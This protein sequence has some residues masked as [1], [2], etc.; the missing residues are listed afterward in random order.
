LYNTNYRDETEVGLKLLQHLNLEH[1][2]WHR[3]GDLHAV[4]V[5][6]II[7]LQLREPRRWQ[8]PTTERAL[9][10]LADPSEDAALV[11]GMAAWHGS[12][13]RILLL[14]QRGIHDELPQADGAVIGARAWRHLRQLPAEGGNV[15]ISDEEVL[16]AVG[17]EPLDVLVGDWVEEVRPVDVPVV[18]WIEID[19][20]IIHANVYASNGS[21]R[22]GSGAR[23]ET[24]RPL[25]P[26]NLHLHRSARGA[27]GG[28][29]GGWNRG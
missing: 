13:R 24:D 3:H 9:T 16:V 21:H 23:G 25:P 1:L 26:A 20:V 14:G 28:G 12:G 29:G 27:N 22:A 2:L 15:I 18:A 7:V 10:L 4:V 19:D 6:V 11:E 17:A 5:M 8:G